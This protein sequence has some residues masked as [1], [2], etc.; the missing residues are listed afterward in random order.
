MRK[1]LW[2]YVL[3]C[4]LVFGMLQGCADENIAAA[5]TQTLVPAETA[6]PSAMPTESETGSKFRVGLSLQDDSPFVLRVGHKLQEL[7]NTYDDDIELVTFNGMANANAQIAHIES[8][9]SSGFDAIILDPISYEKC[10]LAVTIAQNAGI[11]LIVTITETYNPTGYMSFVGSNHYQSGLIEAQMVAEYLNGAGKVVILEGV[12]GI[13]AQTG[14]CEAYVDVL[15]NY[16]DIEIVAVQTAAWQREEAYAI[17]ENWIRNDKD[18]SV[19]LSENDNMAMGAI[20]AIEELGMQDKIAVFGVDGDADALQAVK[21]GRLK[22]TV[23]HNAQKI[24]ESLHDCIL[25][26]KTYETIESSYIIPFEP[27]TQKNVDKYIEEY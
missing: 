25:K 23:F 17:V 9:I 6:A 8:F 5:S 2:V 19:V 7:V 16:P 21:D 15:K 3:A 22:G 13:S 27:V 24:A 12:M 20:Q 11:P 10:A 26:L 4:L 18:F 1:T 14:R